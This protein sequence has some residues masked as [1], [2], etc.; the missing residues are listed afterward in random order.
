MFERLMTDQRK[1]VIV[2]L[3]SL[4]CA[5]LLLWL[6]RGPRPI[7]GNIPFFAISML[8]IPLGYFAV[9][10]VLYLSVRP[11]HISIRTFRRACALIFFGAAALLVVS[12]TS[13]LV[14]FI[15]H[16][17]IPPPHFLALGLA[18]G[19]MKAWGLQRVLRGSGADA[20]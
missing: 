13:A 5:T 9:Y 10:G 19:S 14:E 3:I 11:K 18:L 16:R 2:V 20:R 4:V 1:I 12:A 6:V 8:L 15:N 7:W 17:I